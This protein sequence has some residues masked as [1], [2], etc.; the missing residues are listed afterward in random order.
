MKAICTYAFIPVRREPNEA[1]EMETQILY[2]ETFDVIDTKGRWKYIRMDYDGYEGWIDAKLHIDMDEE[3]IR[4]WADAPRKTVTTTHTVIHSSELNHP[5][6]ISAGSE[7]TENIEIRHDTIIQSARQ[8]LG[9]PYLW[10]GRTF[11]GI[12][13]SGFTQIIYKMHGVVLPR[14]ASQQI[15]MGTTIEF[16]EDATAGDLAFFENDE[17]KITH[18]G[19]CIDNESIIHASGSVRIDKLDHHGIYNSNRKCYTHKL[20]AVKRILS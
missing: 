8:F 16:I 13:C 11:F 15:N 9:T 10:G 2:G 17:G 6:I 7:T 3:L 20:K 14:N 5:L 18:V 19:I 4:K 1:A 12:D